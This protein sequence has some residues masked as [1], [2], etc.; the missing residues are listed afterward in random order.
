MD[1]HSLENLLYGSVTVGERG[2]VVIPASARKGYAL[3]P[4]DKLLML[5]YPDPLGILF[6]KLDQVQAS[7]EELRRSLERVGKREAA[8]LDDEE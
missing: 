2:Q 1:R 8:A 3:D 7:I 5:G 6:T 4:G